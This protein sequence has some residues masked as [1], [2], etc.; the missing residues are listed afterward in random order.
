MKQQVMRCFVGGLGCKCESAFHKGAGAV[1]ATASGIFAVT[2]KISG[3]K[4]VGEL[5]N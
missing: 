3:G 1:S 5:T 2:L 4:E